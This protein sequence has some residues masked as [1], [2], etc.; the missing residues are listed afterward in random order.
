MPVYLVPICFD[1]YYIG[2]NRESEGYSYAYYDV[3][4]SDDRKYVFTFKP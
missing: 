4:N 2:H 1:S 3:E